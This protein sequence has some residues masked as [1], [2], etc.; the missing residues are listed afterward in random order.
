MP[1]FNYSIVIYL[2]DYTNNI[3]NF[4]Y[5]EYW[6]SSATVSTPTHFSAFKFHV[7]KNDENKLHTL[8]NA[9]L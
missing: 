8:Q 7:R 1:N 3:Y 6:V 2:R 9:V 4:A 5:D